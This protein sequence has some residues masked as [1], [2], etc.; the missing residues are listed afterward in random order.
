MKKV[1]L[2]AVLGSIVLTGCFEKDEEVKSV[3]YY[4]QNTSEMQA[5]I[6]EC[7]ANPGELEHTPNCINA[8]KA[9][10]GSGK[11]IPQNW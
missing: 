7:K 10:L 4:K 9:R 5:K 3:D 2:V 11:G 6:K 1:F 8:G